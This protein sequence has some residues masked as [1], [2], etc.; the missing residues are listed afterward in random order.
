MLDCRNDGNIPNCFFFH[1]EGRQQCD[2]GCGGYWPIGCCKP[3]A[4]EALAPFSL[5]PVLDMETSLEGFYS[6]L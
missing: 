1:E 4:A 2:Q 6:A 5:G 3:V